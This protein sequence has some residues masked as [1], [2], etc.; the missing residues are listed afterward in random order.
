MSNEYRLRFSDDEADAM[1]EHDAKMAGFATDRWV[2]SVARVPLEE[3][4]LMVAED[5]SVLTTLVGALRYARWQ[6][7][8]RP[9]HSEIPNSSLP[10]S[11]N[12]QILD[13][14]ELFHLENSSGD[15]CDMAA[16]RCVVRELRE[17]RALDEHRRQSDEELIRRRQADLS[18]FERM[19][20]VSWRER[21]ETDPTIDRAFLAALDKITKER[22]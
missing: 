19:V 2:D 1:L 7:S 17:R 11:K 21:L 13:E 20:I 14:H 9:N 18:N 22:P 6:L 12:W 15:D 10:A 8:M 16:V 5:P 3:M 4:G